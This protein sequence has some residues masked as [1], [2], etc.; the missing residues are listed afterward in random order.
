MNVELPAAEAPKEKLTEQIMVRVTE[1]FYARIIAVCE[2]KNDKP[3][4]LARRAL[5]DLVAR[6]EAEAPAIDAETAELCAQAK[7]LGIDLAGLLRDALAR[8]A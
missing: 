4:E 5:A 8:A 3:A 2:R 1:S 7:A 6:Y